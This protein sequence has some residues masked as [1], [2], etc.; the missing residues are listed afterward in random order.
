M[1]TF[2]KQYSTNNIAHKNINLY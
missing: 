1:Y 2:Y